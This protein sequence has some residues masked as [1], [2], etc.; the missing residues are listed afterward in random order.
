MKICTQEGKKDPKGRKRNIDGK[1]RER[2]GKG[3]R[4]NREVERVR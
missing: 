3:E 2:K 1:R 4:K